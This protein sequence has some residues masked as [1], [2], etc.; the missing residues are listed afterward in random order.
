MNEIKTFLFTAILVMSCHGESNI[1]CIDEKVIDNEFPSETFKEYPQFKEKNDTLFILAVFEKKDWHP[2]YY[3]AF[4]SK[5]IFLMDSLD[6]FKIREKLKE[7]KVEFTLYSGELSEKYKA[8]FNVD[9]FKIPSFEDRSYWK[10]MSTI[11]KTNPVN[12]KHYDELLHLYYESSLRRSNKP[13]MYEL[14]EELVT[15]GIKSK[16]ELALYDTL[17]ML[18]QYNAQYVDTNLLKDIRE[19]LP[20]MADSQKEFVIEDQ[21]PDHLIEDSTR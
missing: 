13:D 18:A 5:M 8:R 1:D 14:F 2:I 12:W 9:E 11:L 17:I 10:I 7:G 6:C 15:N 3:S 4:S 20:G 19:L 16:R 21:I